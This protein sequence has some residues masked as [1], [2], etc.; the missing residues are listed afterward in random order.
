MSV[1]SSPVYTFQCSRLCV[2]EFKA[3]GFG[4]FRLRFWFADRSHGHPTRVL[5]ELLL[6]CRFVGF[7]DLSGSNLSQLIREVQLNQTKILDVGVLMTKSQSHQ[8][9]FLKQQTS[10]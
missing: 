3:Q 9:G 6:R 10:S 8:S 2:R 7:D 1:C 5:K 4:F